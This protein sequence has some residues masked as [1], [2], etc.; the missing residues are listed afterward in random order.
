MLLA[1]PHLGGNMTKSAMAVPAFTDWQ[2]STVNI[3]GS[4]KKKKINEN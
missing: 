2:V 1:T 3:D 4:W